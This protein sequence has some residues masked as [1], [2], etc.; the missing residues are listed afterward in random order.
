MNAE[1][2]KIIY[3]QNF[4]KKSSNWSTSSSTRSL[5]IASHIKLYLKNWKR[6]S[7]RGKL[8]DVGCAT[9]FYS[10]AF[11]KI[12]FDVTGLD[13]SD[14][15]VKLAKEKFPNC[16][17]IQM[18]GFEPQFNSKFDVVFCKGFSGFNT[19]DLTFIST[20]ANKYI[21]LLNPGG[22]LVIGYSSSFTGKEKMNETV[23]HTKEELK[24]FQL[25]INAKYCGNSIFHY[26]GVIS[27]MKK[28]LSRILLKSNKKIEYYLYFQKL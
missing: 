17:F 3:N 13:Y 20:W 26:F 21:T 28:F 7:E 9:G 16:H 27:R 18:N 14:V 23:N 25:L 5:K 19:H 24:S 10:D 2:L 4:L 15:A 11:Q 22:F 1:E 6:N 8:L 12:G